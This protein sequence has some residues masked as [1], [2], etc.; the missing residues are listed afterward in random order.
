MQTS[1]F[2]F[3]FEFSCLHRTKKLNLFRFWIGFHTHE[4]HSE[5][6]IT[7]RLTTDVIINKMDRR[8]F[9]CSRKK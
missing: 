9:S 3:V 5:K 1:L 4:K 8:K 7:T 2:Y 6:K